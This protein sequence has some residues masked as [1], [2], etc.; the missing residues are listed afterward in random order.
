M[1]AWR[2]GITVFITELI[3]HGLGFEVLTAVDMKSS[4]FW[5][6][7]PYSTSKVIRRF[8]AA[9][10]LQLQ[11][12]RISYENNQREASSKETRFTLVI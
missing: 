6:V 9:C 12:R 5:D 2:S 10:R 7:T 11:G 4:I 1:T 8:G 3:N